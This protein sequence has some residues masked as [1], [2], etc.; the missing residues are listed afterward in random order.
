M[1]RKH[2]RWKPPEISIPCVIR[3]HP[4]CERSS[5]EMGPGTISSIQK[6]KWQSIEW[7]LPT[8]QPPK[9]SCPQKSKI[10]TT[11]SAFFA[12]NGII[13]MEFAPLAQT[14]NAAFYE[15]VLKRLL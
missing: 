10:K 12:N 14:V 8:S 1:T 13:H 2:A 7:C 11:L 3:I 5:Q 9:K 15:E 6:L 4:S